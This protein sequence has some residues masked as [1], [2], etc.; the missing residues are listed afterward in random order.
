MAGGAA[1]ALL[2]ELG[3]LGRLSN[4]GAAQLAADLDYFCNVLAALGVALSPPLL[5]WQAR[6][7]CSVE[8]ISCSVLA[9]ALCCQSCCLPGTWLVHHSW[10]IVACEPAAVCLP[11]LT[12]RCFCLCLIAVH[13]TCMQ[14]STWH[15]AWMAHG[16]R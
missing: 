1:E 9:S 5:T 12:P 13:T 3:A 2:E 11:R 7:G 14:G 6:P 8:L 15:F 4:P 10:V 16:H